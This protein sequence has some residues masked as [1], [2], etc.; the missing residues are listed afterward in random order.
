MSACPAAPLDEEPPAQRDVMLMVGE[1]RW[2]S[3]ALNV[4]WVV[5]GRGCARAECARARTR[6]GVRAQNYSP[7]H[8]NSQGKAVLIQ[9]S[10]YYR[11]PRMCSQDSVEEGVGG[12][13]G[14]SRREVDMALP[15]PIHYGS[16]SPGPQT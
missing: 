7:I 11:T 9:Q 12:D 4:A 14:M 13:G 15:C 8:P 6:T 16:T 2:E 3:T 1:G 10:P 5:L